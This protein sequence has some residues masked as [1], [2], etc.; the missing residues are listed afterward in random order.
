MKS[1]K[2]LREELLEDPE[3]RK[4]Y[5]KLKPRYE[6]I[7]QL[8]GAR[9]KKGLTQ[10]QLAKRMGTKQS[11]IARVEG[12][13][14]NPSVAFLQKLATALNSKLTIQIQP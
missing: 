6:L 4:E 1:W 13:N 3:V 2:V 7:S 8:I 10:A 14:A 11:A 12:G 9:A 5:E